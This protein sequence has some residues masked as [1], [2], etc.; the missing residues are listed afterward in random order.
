MPMPKPKPMP[1]EH[2]SSRYPHDASMLEEASMQQFI[3][4]KAACALHVDEFAGEKK[5]M[6]VS[7]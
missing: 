4:S 1:R 7:M 2:G 3:R 5:Y 6:T